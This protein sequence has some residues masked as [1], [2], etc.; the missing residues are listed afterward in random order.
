MVC[1]SPEIK[2]MTKMSDELKAIILHTAG[3][4]EASH[5]AAELAATNAACLEL[6]RLLESAVLVPKEKQ[7]LEAELL[8]VVDLRSTAARTDQRI[9]ERVQDLVE[10]RYSLVS[11]QVAECRLAD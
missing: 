1:V 4:Q 9:S 6:L 3:T 10:V 7:E 5:A 11:A 8:R 2:L